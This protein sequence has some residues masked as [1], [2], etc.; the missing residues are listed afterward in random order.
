MNADHCRNRVLHALWPEFRVIGPALRIVD[1]I[2]GTVLLQRD[3]RLRHVWF[4]LA[5]SLSVIGSL[6]SGAQVQACA[7]GREGALGLVE[8]VND[9]APG[10]T[11]T[12]PAGARLSICT[13]D[14]FRRLHAE[15]ERVR[16]VTLQQA[17]DLAQTLIEK[18]TCQAVH[19]VEARLCRWLLECDERS[20]STDIRVTQETLASLLGVQRTT[21]C[22]VMSGLQAAGLAS[23]GRGTI[24]LVDRPG[25]RRRACGCETPVGVQASKPRIGPE[26]LDVLSPRS[27]TADR[28]G[29]RQPQR[30]GAS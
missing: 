7:V 22:Q 24:K 25:L 16:G 15:S 2:P 26:R 10:F 13:A 17:S 27:I 29:V 30:V 14:A 6:P 9:R 3:D 11:V 8:A 1:V 28:S 21:V 20:D 23:T 4:P 19:G 12:C 5:G 18:A